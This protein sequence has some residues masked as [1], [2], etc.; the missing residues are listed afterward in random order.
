MNRLSLITV[1]ALMLCF[2]GV[3][4]GFNWNHY[5]FAA[6]PFDADNNTSPINYPYGVGYL[7]SPGVLGEGGEHYDLEGMFVALDNDYLYVGLANSF[8]YSAYSSSWGTSFNMGDIF[9]GTNANKNAFAI[10]ISSGNL[11]SV[12]TWNY[13]NNKSGSYYS[14]TTIRNRIGAFEMATGSVLGGANQTV[15]FWDDLETNPLLPG[16]GDTY[17][18]EWKINRANLSG[19][20]GVS[21]LYFHATLGCGNDLIERTFTPIPEPGTVILLGIGLFGFGLITRR[22]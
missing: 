6:S 22:K 9:F 1:V 21:N 13:I 19:W 8:G 18:F 11:Y 17:V 14:N 10:D 7:P 4:M 16:N 15:T 2:T 12:S 3:A 5:N 20:D